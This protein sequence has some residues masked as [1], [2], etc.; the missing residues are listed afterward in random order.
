[1]RY[2][3]DA[4]SVLS[5]SSSSLCQHGKTWRAI[6]TLWLIALNA[7]SGFIELTCS[8]RHFSHLPNLR[9]IFPWTAVLSSQIVRLTA[10]HR[11]LGAV[12]L[13]HQQF[14]EALVF[15]KPS[16]QAEAAYSRSPACRRDLYL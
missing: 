4:S 2:V 15:L 9:F 14:P 5:L 11:L 13:E 6:V 8:V 7:S 12:E 10:Y 16:F 3:Y 1:M